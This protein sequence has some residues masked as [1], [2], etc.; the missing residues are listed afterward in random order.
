M[1]LN[2][3][4]TRARHRASARVSSFTRFLDHTRRRTTV[5]RTPLGKWSARR[6]GLYLTTHNTHNRQTYMPAV[7][8]E[9]TI[10]ADERPQTYALECAAT[11]INL[12]RTT[13]CIL[14][15]VKHIIKYTLY[16]LY[17][18]VLPSV[19]VL[20]LRKDLSICIQVVWTECHYSQSKFTFRKIL[21][22]FRKVFFNDVVRCWRYSVSD[23]WIN[24][25]CSLVEYSWQGKTDHNLKEWFY[26]F[27]LLAPEFYI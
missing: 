6:R 8:F 26:G 5:G 17:Y 21:L 18:N 7:G 16:E 13:P 15:V 22:N 24:E 12:Q 19:C 4:G 9:P 10:S 20:L 1:T 27:D 25:C 2:Y 3:W 23:T 11:G 14:H